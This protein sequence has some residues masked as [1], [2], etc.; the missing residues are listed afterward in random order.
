MLKTN[1]Q[2]AIENTW[3]HICEHLSDTMEEEQISAEEILLRDIDNMHGCFTYDKAFI[4]VSGGYFDIYYDDAR[5]SLKNILE[6]TDE[7]A[8]QYDNEQVW[9]LYC[10]LIAKTIEKKLKKYY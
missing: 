9:K 3:E 10:H 8:N 2:K 6:E 4:M 5:Q 1:T 7:E